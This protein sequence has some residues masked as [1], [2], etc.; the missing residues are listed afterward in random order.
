MRF[1][2]HCKEIGLLSSSSTES[3]EEI[4]QLQ[5]KIKQKRQQN[6]A[7]KIKDNRDQQAPAVSCPAVTDLVS[8]KCNCSM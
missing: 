8:S 2:G 4:A 3:D 7:R 1:E 6:L 5:E